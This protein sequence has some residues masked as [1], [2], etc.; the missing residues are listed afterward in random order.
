MEGIMGL[1]SRLR[2]KLPDMTK[3]DAS[4]TIKLLDD[5]E[6]IYAKL[7]GLDKATQA[8]IKKTPE[9]IIFLN[10][11][12]AEEHSDMVSL[13][14]WLKYYSKRALSHP[15][16]RDIFE[17]LKDCVKL[18]YDRIKYLRDVITKTERVCNH[19]SSAKSGT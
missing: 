14:R 7:L 6:V 17:G 19:I 8:K 1:I 18:S 5:L 11:L 13:E 4:Y 2:E 3:E 9:S 15:D 10:G 16:E 12:L